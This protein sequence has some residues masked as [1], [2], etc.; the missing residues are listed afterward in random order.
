MVWPAVSNRVYRPSRCPWLGP[1]SAIG[2][3]RVAGNSVTSRSAF[4][5]CPATVHGSSIDIVKKCLDA[6]FD[7]IMIDASEQTFEENVRT[8][9]EAVK[10]AEPFKAN[11]EAELGYVA[12]LGQQQKAEPTS[13]ADAKRFAEARRLAS[14]SVPRARWTGHRDRP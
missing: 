11:V 10:I 2:F 8:T 7:S 9:C 13:A 3:R 4:F 12:K 14:R 6:G 1:P 5:H